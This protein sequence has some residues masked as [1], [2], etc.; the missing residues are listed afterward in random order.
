[1]GTEQQYNSVKDQNH[2]ISME[3]SKMRD[4]YSTDIQRSKHINY[5]RPL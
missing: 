4:K 1:M 2:L 3:S 5:Q